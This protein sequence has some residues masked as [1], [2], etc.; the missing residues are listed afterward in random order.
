MPKVPNDLPVIKLRN[1]GPTCE[2]DLHSAGIRTAG[3][4]RKLGAKEAFLRLMVA[5]EKSGRGGTCYNAAYLYALYGAI[6]DLDWREIP[7][8]KRNEFKAFTA[9]LREG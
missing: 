9:E 5:R 1:I 2:K 3:D 4:I 7:E 8:K 6:H